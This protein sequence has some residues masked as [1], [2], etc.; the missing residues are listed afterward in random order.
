M[1]NNMQNQTEMTEQ[2]MEG[3]V[4]VEERKPEF[5]PAVDLF[6]SEDSFLLVT[7][8]PGVSEDQIEVTVEKNIL[9]ITGKTSLS[10]KLEG[11]RLTYSESRPGNFKRSFT[12][13]EE[14]DRDSIQARFKDGV[15]HLELKRVKP[16]VKK[17]QIQHS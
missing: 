1:E 13:S 17:I 16:E 2:K 8:L 6:E 15:L 3:Q 5:I 7:D 14:V 10:E 11:F 9:T 4:Q 12:L